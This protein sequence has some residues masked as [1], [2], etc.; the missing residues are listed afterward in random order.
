ML[1]D[2]TVY[3]RMLAHASDPATPH[4]NLELL[5]R[6]AEREM[7]SDHRGYFSRIMEGDAPHVERAT[8]L[9][10][11]IAGNPNASATTLQ[12]LADYHADVVLRNPVFLLL[13][14]EDPSLTDWPCV[15]IAHL[16]RAAFEYGH[17]LFSHLAKICKPEW[18][19]AAY[20]GDMPSCQDPRCAVCFP[21]DAAVA[22]KLWRERS[23]QH[24]A[25]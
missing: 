25:Q 5:A 17:D 21:G 14:L 15:S 19:Y 22:L 24:V 8:A 3:T 18:C 2:N 11:A 9:M 23:A 20:R 12:W 7:T 16:R 6:V 4:T 1:L 13:L 10:R